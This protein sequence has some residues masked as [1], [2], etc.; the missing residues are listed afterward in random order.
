MS[1]F[2]VF[3]S[4]AGSGKTFNL[5]L[6][7]LQICMEAEHPSK[8]RQIL[9]LTFTNKA[10]QE[11]KERILGSL[12]ELSVK[13]SKSS[14]LATLCEVTGLSD[15][16]VRTKSSLVL[17]YIL[18]HYSDF[19]VSTIDG[20]VFKLIRSFSRDLQLDSDLQ[21]EMDLEGF[22]DRMISL[23]IAKAG[24]DLVITEVLNGFAQYKIDEDKSYQIEKD[25]TEMA[26]LARMESN[27][28]FV[29]LLEP[30]PPQQ[31]TEL[32]TIYK[33]RKA[34]LAEEFRKMGEGLLA[35]LEL[36]GGED[37]SFVRAS[38]GIWAFAKNVRYFKNNSDALPEPNRY[39][40]ECLENDIWH[41]SKAPQNIQ[42]AIMAAAPEI[43]ERVGK[44]MNFIETHQNYFV[45][46]GLVSPHLFSMALIGEMERLSQLLCEQENV[47]LISDFNKMISGFIRNEQAPFIFERLGNR[48][49]YFMLDEFQDTSVMQWRNLLPLITNALASGGSAMLFGDSKQAIYRWRNGE[50]R[51]FHLMPAL[52][53]SAVTAEE[54]LAEETLSRYFCPNP[55]DD[56]WRSHLEIVRFNNTF[57]ETVA[58]DAVPLLV[59]TGYEQSAQNPMKKEEKG[60]VTC[61]F[62]DAKAEDETHIIKSIEILKDCMA[63]GASADDICILVRT[64]AEGAAMA[65]ALMANKIP[66]ISQ[67]C[68]HLGAN[69]Y[70]RA[71]MGM[72]A[73]LGNKAHPGYGL[74]VLQLLREQGRVGNVHE[75]V[76][77]NGKP[78]SR[79]YDSEIMWEKLLNDAGIANNREHFMAAS[80]V[81]TI[82][83][84]AAALQVNQHDAV[85]STLTDL[86]NDFQKKR[87]YNLTLLLKWWEEKGSTVSI[88]GDASES[89]VQIMT[90][91]KA[92][93]LQFPVVILPFCNWS[94][95]FLSAFTWIDNPEKDHPATHLLAQIGQRLQKT[96]FSGHYDTEQN[97]SL[98]DNINLLYVA[99]TRPVCELHIV[100]TLSENPS[101]LKH[102]GDILQ[103]VL[104][105]MQPENEG[106][107]YAF[108]HP[109][110]FAKSNVQTKPEVQKHYVI[111]P[112]SPN[113]SANVQNEASRTG[114]QFH[115]VI[116]A[117]KTAEEV[118]QAFEQFVA[119][120]SLN[121]TDF[122]V[123]EQRLANIISNE[124]I[125]QLV[126]PDNFKEIISENDF[127]SKDG[128]ILRPDR[129]IDS[130]DKLIVIDFKTGT[131][132]NEKY[133]TQMNK[134]AECLSEIWHK[135]VLS[136]IVYTDNSTVQPVVNA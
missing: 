59:D 30:I 46:T 37:K 12:A 131:L 64:N 34:V 29:E 84:I 130:Q 3:R 90:V 33:N 111:T 136:F 19:S 38:Q 9:A 32:H 24:D 40:T 43:S 88:A 62:L 83:I 92:K 5:V 77:N 49:Q 8:V 63:R 123:L 11:M 117:C 125:R 98:V 126:F 25:L 66:V 58:K 67:E 17:S 118:P 82:P 68:L 101:S 94:L 128:N 28:V 47:V 50:W 133:I 116:A 106:E 85:Y 81:Q 104:A 72:L 2:K 14:Y 122:Q 74:D 103:L 79:F 56:N 78:D 16:D 113:L 87:G 105:I 96:Q 132:E 69:L 97:Q 53:P 36:V 89:A 31:L 95:G 51:Q 39:V 55:L 124:Q 21:V 10:A 109:F 13:E 135:K 71:M 70:A 114:E 26:K 44:I 107:K 80:L 100:S 127:F 112:A 108:G 75:Y 35:I 57:F 6:N 65:N 119:K 91:H 15:S 134:Y 93:G 102:T 73:W 52:F 4:S 22:R 23:L 27:R 115:A 99:F 1:Q 110:E 7:Y 42:N 18:H 60:Y 45:I 121:Q 41:N 129:I 76:K 120:T 48:Y 20:F 86:L 54:K 61:T